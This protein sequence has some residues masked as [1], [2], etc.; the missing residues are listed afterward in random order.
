MKPSL[1]FLFKPRNRNRFVY[2]HKNDY[3]K[4]KISCKFIAIKKNLGIRPLWNASILIDSAQD[5]EH[6]VIIWGLHCPSKFCSVMHY[7]MFP[8]AKLKQV[9]VVLGSFLWPFS[10]LI[11]ELKIARR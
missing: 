8:F 6:D 10:I 3:D 5:Y 11:T 2:I 7:A 9:G 1:D 4:F